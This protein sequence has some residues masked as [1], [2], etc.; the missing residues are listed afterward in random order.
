MVPEEGGSHTEPGEG[1][2]QRMRR[3][4]R[5]GRNPRSKTGSK[6]GGEIIQ[7]EDRTWGENRG[8]EPKKGYE[9]LSYSTAHKWPGRILYK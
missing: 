8:N 9:K 5:G 6:R 7:Q 4:V 3:R 1:A 2:R